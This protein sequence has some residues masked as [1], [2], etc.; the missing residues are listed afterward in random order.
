MQERLSSLLIEC[1]GSRATPS[2]VAMPPRPLVQSTSDQHDPVLSALIAS[3]APGAM[4]SEQAGS[5]A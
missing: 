5:W 3:A 1:S 4:L 2:D